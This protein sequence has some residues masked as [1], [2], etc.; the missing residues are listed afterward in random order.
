MTA[1]YTATTVAPTAVIIAGMQRA[2]AA[3]CFYLFA[4]QE[5]KM[6]TEILTS[7][8]GKIVTVKTIGDYAEGVLNEVRGYFLVIAIHKNAEK[9]TLVNAATIETIKIKK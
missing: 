3:K 8:L 9:V 2:Q 1:C 5:K 4:L 7:F 6:D